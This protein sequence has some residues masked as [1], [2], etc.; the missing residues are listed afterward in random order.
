METRT[1]SPVLLP[2]PHIGSQT[3]ALSHRPQSSVFLLE[4]FPN[5]MHSAFSWPPESDF[6]PTQHF[7][8]EIPRV[9]LHD[10]LKTLPTPISL[11]L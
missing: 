9:F 4:V 1:L 8:R 3:P 5:R 6:L 2:L 11:L 7:Y 10:T